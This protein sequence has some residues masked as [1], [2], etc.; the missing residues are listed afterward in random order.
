MAALMAALH[1]QLGPLSPAVVSEPE[2]FD[3][4]WARTLRE[5]R[6]YDPEARTIERVVVDQP[7]TELRYWDFSF[8]G[9]GG[10]RVNAWL[11]RPA[12]DLTEVLPC[13]VQI[14]GYGRGRGLPGEA[15][16]L[17]AAGMAHLLLDVRGQGCGYGSGGDTPDPH[18]GAPEAPGVVTRGIASPETYYYRRLIVDAVR[19][20]DAVR[21]L[22]D[23]DAERII[24]MGNSQGGGVTLAVAGLVPDLCGVTVSVPFLCDVPAVYQSAQGEPYAELA[25]YL[26]VRRTERERVFHT[27]AYVD[28]VNHARRAQAPSL[29]GL[30]LRDTCCPTVGGQQALA[31]YAGP[32]QAEIYPDNGHE[33]GEFFYL[34]RQ[35]AWIRER[36]AAPTH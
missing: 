34:R 11:S 15:P 3:R 25:R 4:F 13:V 33:G 6:G 21:T 10:Q 5:A 12:R 1:P 14:P 20:V 26:A 2:D 30:G 8:S 19:S 28:G 31:A 29:W 18:D 16:H 7:L 22:P 9:F 36:C 17:A 24:V 27:L 32:A 35:L 23:I